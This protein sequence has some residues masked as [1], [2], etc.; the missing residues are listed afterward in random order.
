MF[1]PANHETLS[2]PKA[3]FDKVSK[4]SKDLESQRK[5]KS[6]KKEAALGED[7]VTSFK[8]IKTGEFMISTNLPHAGKHFFI[9]EELN[10][11]VSEPE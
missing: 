5:K 9:E 4:R 7:G 8:E 2:D 3:F 11:D 6:Y 1:S 10:S